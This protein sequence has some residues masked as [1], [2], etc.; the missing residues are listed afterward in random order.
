MD[1]YIEYLHLDKINV[2]FGA[3]DCVPIS[4]ANEPCDCVATLIKLF[5]YCDW[6]LGLATG[7]I[8][9]ATG[10]VP[11]I[12]IVATAFCV[13]SGLRLILF[14]CILLGRALRLKIATACCE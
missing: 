14:F 7:P 10:L 12:H 8:M 11:R 1:F 2:R 4:L 13:A 5:D 9:L 6:A 3:S